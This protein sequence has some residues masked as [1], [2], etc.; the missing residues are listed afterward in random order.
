MQEPGFMSAWTV[1]LFG[2]NTVLLCI[3]LLGYIVSCT[4]YRCSNSIFMLLGTLLHAVECQGHPIP[5]LDNVWLAS[6]SS[7]PG[8]LAIVLVCCVCLAD[9]L[10]PCSSISTGL[11]AED[12]YEHLS[13]LKAGFFLLLS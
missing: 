13:C 1:S 11:C 8:Q 10:C 12:V 3:A 6:R 7:S 2:S 5:G 9:V 4:L